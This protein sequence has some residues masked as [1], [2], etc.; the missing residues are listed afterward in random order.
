MNVREK[1]TEFNGL[2]KEKSPLFLA[3]FLM[4]IVAIPIDVISQLFNLK[5]PNEV[6]AII[7]LI[8][9]TP[10]KDL[11]FQLLF[12]API[13]EEFQYRGP[14]R[15]LTWIFPKL[16]V[17]NPIVWIFIAVPTWYWAFQ[18]WSIRFDLGHAY[19]LVIFFVGLVFG[20]IVVKTK[21]LESAILLHIFYNAI[22]L[23]GALIKFKVL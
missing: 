9:T 21:T 3:F 22:N 19:G 5:N 8:K 13:I 4:I 18:S 10:L 12:I 16:T 23:I 7:D 15:L 2:F 14:V 11:A 17:K 20:Y 6:R 1:I